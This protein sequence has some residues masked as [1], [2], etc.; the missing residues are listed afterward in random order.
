MIETL[1]LYA[2]L[3][4]FMT[5][6]H[7]LADFPLQPLAMSNAKRPGGSES[8]HWTMAL[9]CHSLVHGGFV[10]ATAAVLAGCW[11]LGPIELVSHAAIDGAKCR[12]WFGMKT[13]QALHLG[14]KLVW[15][16]IAVA[17]S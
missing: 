12:G 7:A 16:A 15:A 8:I 1:N 4:F 17:A 2:Q 6:G 11:W 5:A 14:C 9:G 3:V 10:G 13:D